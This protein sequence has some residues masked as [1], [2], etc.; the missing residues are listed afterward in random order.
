M[1]IIDFVK[2]KINSFKVKLGLKEV[3]PPAQQI[4]ESGTLQVLV[5]PIARRIKEEG[6]AILS[7]GSIS[8]GMFLSRSGAYIIGTTPSVAGVV[9]VIG[10]GTITADGSEQI[11]VEY[12]GSLSRISGFIDLSNMVDGDSIT[13]RAYVKIKDGGN[14]VT[15]KPETY[16]NS[17]PEQALY[18]LP[19]LSGYGYKITI[20]QTSGTYKSYDYLFVKIP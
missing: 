6:G 9:E 19:R 12:S 17:Q 18:F 3:P 10:K 8:D 4:P 15:Y 11:V 14:Y 16:S 5:P 1:S 20:Q 7:I 2:N 13:V